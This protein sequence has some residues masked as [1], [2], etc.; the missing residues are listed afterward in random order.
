MLN[1]IASLVGAGLMLLGVSAPALAY[2]SHGSLVRVYNSASSMA[3]TGN[4]LQGNGLMID[5]SGVGSA[6]GGGSNSMTTGEANAN[7]NT[8][9]VVNATV[10]GWGYSHRLVKVTNES[11][12]GA[13]TGYNV[14]GNTALIDHSGVGEVGFGGDN[15]M[16]TGNANASANASSTVNLTVNSVEEF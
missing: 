16:T 8:S 11:L 12:A 14:Q 10:N 9:S 1:K 6:N 3:D 13:N 4:N 5:H 15:T 7:A 2:Y